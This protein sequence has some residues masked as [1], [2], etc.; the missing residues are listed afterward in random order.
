MSDS[1][2]ISCM[3]VG[4]PGRI[5]KDTISC[6]AG[7]G[8]P[9]TLVSLSLDRCYTVTAAGEFPMACYASLDLFTS[10]QLAANNFM[11]IYPYLST[12]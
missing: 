9:K 7:G 3:R 11:S 12:L 1:K 2:K 8:D 6:G 5:P 10:S 4:I